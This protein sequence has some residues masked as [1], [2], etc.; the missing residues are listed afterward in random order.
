VV[1]IFL[2]HDGELFELRLRGPITV[3]CAPSVASAIGYLPDGCGAIVDLTEV[4][5][6]DQAG[7]EAIRQGLVRGR[8]GALRVV[9]AAADLQVRAALVSLD[10]DRLV[11]VLPTLE[12][13]RQTLASVP[14]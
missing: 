2:V 14:A 13:A 1:D 10:V 7:A 8:P 6:I 12:L 9:L 3:D 5:S 11:P 4:P